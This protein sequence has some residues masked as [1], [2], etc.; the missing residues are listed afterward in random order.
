MQNISDAM[1]LTVLLVTP[2][3]TL[4][5]GGIAGYAFWQKLLVLMVLFT[6]VC[7][8]IYQLLLRRLMSPER[9]DIPYEECVR[10]MGRMTLLSYI[11]TVGTAISV[12]IYPILDL[13]LS[14]TSA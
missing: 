5:K 3:V 11:I 1:N 9:W 7:F 12:F 6:L 14:S 10:Q 2:V 4:L 13:M 8:V